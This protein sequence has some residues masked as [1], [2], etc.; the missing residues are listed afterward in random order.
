MLKQRIITAICLI[1]PVV[2]AVLWLPT[3][4]LVWPLALIAALTA[5]EW[6]GLYRNSRGVRWLYSIAAAMLVV[7]GFVLLPASILGSIVLIGAVA[8]LLAPLL[9]VAYER[10]TWQRQPRSA[11]MAVA[12]LLLLLPAWLG[13]LALHQY[14]VGGSGW[15]LFLFVLIWGAD[16]AAYFAG[17]RWGRRRLAPRISPGKTLAGLTGALLSGVLLALLTAVFWQ[18]GA[19]MTLGLLALTLITV[20]IS[21]VG[22]L[23]ESLCKR[24]A[25]VKDSGNLLPGHGGLLDRIDSM[26]AAT[27]VFVTGL[28]LL[29]VVQ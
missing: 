18:P 6:T 5:W 16:S 1:L 12:G 26:M 22:D 27:P 19:A 23:V 21:V 29:G 17:R 20:I 11:L 25:G 8:W 7:A 2:A 9:L 3:G 24:Q 13:L 4:W 10:G 15:V 28:W 14:A